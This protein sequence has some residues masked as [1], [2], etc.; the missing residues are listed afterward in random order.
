[1]TEESTTQELDSELE[2]EFESQNDLNDDAS[3]EKSEKERELE[4]ALAR[5]TAELAEFRE[6]QA[7]AEN[8]A[9]WK[10]AP[11]EEKADVLRDRYGATREDEK[12][13]LFEGFAEAEFVAGLVAGETD[14]IVAAYDTVDGVV[15]TRILDALADDPDRQREVVTRALSDYTVTAPAQEAG[16]D[17]A[18][19]APIDW[20]A[21]WAQSPLAE[22]VEVDRYAAQGLADVRTGKIQVVPEL[23]EQFEAL[24]KTADS[25]PDG[26]GHRTAA[27]QQAAGLAEF[28]RTEHESSVPFGLGGIRTVKHYQ[29]SDGWHQ[30]EI[31]GRGRERDT[32]IENPTFAS[33]AGLVNDGP[34]SDVSEFDPESVKTLEDALRLSPDQWAKLPD[35][36][37]EALLRSASA[38]IETQEL[39]TRTGNL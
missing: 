35:D 37:R 22:M 1:M 13:E 2:D 30:L 19:P 12:R 33:E 23:R 8:Y 21:L 38:E 16:E 20:G 26:H 36:R 25:L 10:R 39:Q 15:W 18:E 14:A 5:G 17:G 32:L 28:I 29:A 24:M 7:D 27:L 31:D 6:Q 34:V 11:E 3:E 9:E 4:E